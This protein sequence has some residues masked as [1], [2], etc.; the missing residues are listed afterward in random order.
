MF[1]HNLKY[2]LKYLLRNRVLVFW[3][4]VFPVILGTLFH[5]AFSDMVNK[6]KLS[7]INIAV[8]QNQTDS[9]SGIS[10]KSVISE[11]S[12]SSSSGQLFNA[13]YIDR[14]E[15][16]LQLADNKIDGFIDFSGEVPTITIKRNGVNQTV[17]KYVVDEI[18]QTEAI[19]KDVMGN[20]IANQTNTN[21]SIDYKLVDAAV[22]RAVN[23]QQPNID[24]QS[25]DNL[26]YTMIE[27]FTLIAMACLYGSMFGV[28]ITN[29][30]L[31]N[32][33]RRGSRIAVS[34][35][36]KMTI[37]SSGLLAAWLVS[38][39]GVAIL[40]AYT[41]VLLKVNYGPRLDLVVI[42]AAA[43]SLA[44]VSLGI[45]VGSAF[46]ANDNT[47]TGILIGLT[48]L[49]SFLTGMMGVQIKYLID[50]HVGFINQINPAAMITDGFYSLYYYDSIDRYIFNLI[51]LLAFAA[52]TL[53]ISFV[54][55]RRQRYDSI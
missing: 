18:A 33:S 39:V 40:L 30:S 36:H 1:L 49:A 31:P 32:M 54:I 12:E 6:E 51:S 13:K 28:V 55:M 44:G 41:I 23:S 9:Q 52:I 47:K 34:R 29:Q 15:A 16:E 27:Y 14:D 10:A 45:L 35:A 25:D 3:A 53:V 7:P 20:I 22:A 48:M 43:G 24:D 38:L 11:L 8:I 5:L 46:K 42:L 37:I 2:F 26:D 21:R 17:I 50:T 4:F 19:T